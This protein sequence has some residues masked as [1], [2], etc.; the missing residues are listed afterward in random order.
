MKKSFVLDIDKNDT[1]LCSNLSPWKKSF[2]C[3][4]KKPMDGCTQGPQSMEKIPPD[5]EKPA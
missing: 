3:Y 4:W 5:I 2:H 1:E